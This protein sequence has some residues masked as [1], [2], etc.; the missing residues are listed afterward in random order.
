MW[1]TIL[2]FNGSL[3]ASSI[4]ERGYSMKINKS[5]A[6]IILT[7]GIIGLASVLL[8]QLGNPQNMGFCIACFLRDIAGAC[9]LHSAAVVQYFRPEVVGLIAGSMIMALVGKE[10]SARGGSAPVTRFF[11]GAFV[12]IGALVFLG[13]PLR[14]VLRIA[15]GDL[16]GVVGLV[17]FACGIFTGIFFLNKGFSL[18]RTYNLPK[19]EGFMLPAI[20]GLLFALSLLA[21]ALFAHSEKGPGSKFAPVLIALAAGLVVGALCQKSRMCMVA[22]IRDLTLF[23]D[24]KLMLGFAAVIVAAFIGNLMTGNF[25]LGFTGQPVAHAQHLWNLLGMYAVGFGSVLLG[26]CPLR[27][28]ILTGEGNADSAITVLGYI[29]GA[30]FAHNFGLAGAAASAD[31]LGGPSING[32][33]AVIVGIVFMAAVALLNMESRKKSA[34]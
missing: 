26:G 29:V 7:G 30:A 23:K 5:Y 25:H 14:M 28:L 32:K 12:M 19:A 2:E 27:Q 11:L 18:K 6:G 24:W 21:P 20:M 8:V 31:S 16:N 17:G 1:Q 10:F 4:E 9:K 34:K 15:G 13:C 3:G 22:G 33:I